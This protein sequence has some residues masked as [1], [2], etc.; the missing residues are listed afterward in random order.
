MSFNFKSRPV[1]NGLPAG[2]WLFVLLMLSVGAPAYSQSLGDIAR[3][4]Q[5][6][7]REQPSHTTHVYD[8]DDLAR[9]HILLPED[10]KRIE[11]NKKMSAPAPDES[12]AETAT[13]EPKASAGATAA[14]PTVAQTQIV[15]TTFA[16]SGAHAQA[17][18]PSAPRMTQSL[19][20]FAQ[21]AALAS[22]A[23]ASA[24]PSPSRVVLPRRTQT[25]AQEQLLEQPKEVGEAA[26]HSEISGSRQ[27]RV[28]QGDTMWSLAR[29]YLGAGKD[30]LV[31][32]ACNPQAKDPMRLQVGMAIQL[33]EQAMNSHLPNT[34]DTVVVQRGDSLWK[35]ARVHLGDGNEWSCVAQANPKLQNSNRI[36]V[37]QAVT[38]PENCSSPLI[39]RA[40]HVGIPAEALPS[41]T[42]QLLQ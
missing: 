19:P 17:R 16:V 11:A 4:E 40:V 30:W 33:P 24:A 23:P 29:K 34:P 8:N 41:A 35:L 31:L 22:A 39:A 7:K 13:S 36:F 25:G 18:Q 26:L 12:A 32:A 14:A 15:K 10:E 27:I 42:S 38:I 28:R 2:S 9:P 3:Q 37:G 5:E 6:R 20:A 1:N 21:P